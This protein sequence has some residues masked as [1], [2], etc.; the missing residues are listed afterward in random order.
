M[1]TGYLQADTISSTAAGKAADS[2]FA[3]PVQSFTQGALHD[4]LFGYKV[5]FDI[6]GRNN[7]LIR[8][9]IKVGTFPQ[10]QRW[11]FGG[12]NSGSYKMVEHITV[13]SEGAQSAWVY[14]P[15]LPTTFHFAAVPG[16]A[17]SGAGSAGVAGAPGSGAVGPWGVPRSYGIH[18]P[19]TAVQLLDDTAPWMKARYAMGLQER[20]GCSRLCC[21]VLCAALYS[22]CGA[23]AAGGGIGRPQQAAAGCVAPLWFARSPALQTCVLTTNPLSFLSFRFSI[24]LALTQSPQTQRHTTSHNATQRDTTRHNRAPSGPSTTSSSRAAAR[25]SRA[26]AA[27]STTCRRGTP[28]PHSPRPLYPPYPPA[29]PLSAA[30]A[31]LLLSAER[32]TSCA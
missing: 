5:D 23:A 26:A 31:L 25:A 29:P 1:A 14:D 4:H 3:V 2:P 20:Y 13:Q 8:S 30:A 12:P 15:A 10:A 27:C 18:I 9:D 22:L 16:A 21:A 19:G 11:N 7:T 24:I 17:G 28:K 32:A 6:M